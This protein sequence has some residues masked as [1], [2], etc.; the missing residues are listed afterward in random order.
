MSEQKQQKGAEVFQSLCD[1]LT[2]DGW[3][4][5]MVDDLHLVTHATGEDLPMALHVLVHTGFEN[6]IAYS[7]LPVN[8]PEDKRMD[9]AVAVNLINNKLAIGCFQFNVLEDKICFQM[10]NC[11]AGFQPPEE[12]FRYML[13]GSCQVIDEFN[14]MFLMLAKGL[15]TLEQFMSKNATEGGNNNE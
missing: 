2:K 14:D 15:I 5:E 7:Y 8:V 13:Y 1:Y 4:Y 3:R 9:M 12:I 6:I 10:C 11:Y